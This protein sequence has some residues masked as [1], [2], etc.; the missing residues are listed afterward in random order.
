M[1]TVKEFQAQHL[2]KGSDDNIG[3]E[4]FKFETARIKTRILSLS[5]IFE[6]FW[7]A[8]RFFIKEKLCW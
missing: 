6:T 2:K 7:S 4:N 3:I 8:L 1:S 5:A